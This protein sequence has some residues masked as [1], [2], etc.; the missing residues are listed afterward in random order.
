MFFVM[1]HTALFF[2]FVQKLKLT[3]LCDVKKICQEV[4]NGL[5]QKLTFEKQACELI[6]EMVWRKVQDYGSDL[7]LFSKYVLSLFLMWEK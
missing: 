2:I 6:A 7:E 1:L 4:S 3:V 5:T